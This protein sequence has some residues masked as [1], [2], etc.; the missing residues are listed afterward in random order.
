VEGRLPGEPVA[1]AG[2]DAGPDPEAKA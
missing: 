1:D 2:S